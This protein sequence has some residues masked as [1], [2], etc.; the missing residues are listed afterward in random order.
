MERSERPLRVDSGLYL[1]DY[2][3]APVYPIP[4]IPRL[5]PEVLPVFSPPFTSHS[6]L[7]A[8]SPHYS[9]A[10]TVVESDLEPEK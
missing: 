8:G 3:M 1:P 5:R 6:A 4:A 9:T 7:V 10:I 2:E